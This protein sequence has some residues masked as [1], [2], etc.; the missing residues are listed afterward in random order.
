M[1]SDGDEDVAV[2]AVR[3]LTIVEEVSEACMHRWGYRHRFILLVRHALF[4]RIRL[5][6]VR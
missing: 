4:G 3:C 2:G 6:H 5:R 1:G